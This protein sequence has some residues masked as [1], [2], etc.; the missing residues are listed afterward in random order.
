MSA[1]VIFILWTFTFCLFSVR[2]ITVP[3]IS[4][5]SPSTPVSTAGGTPLTITGVYFLQPGCAAPTSSSLASTSNGVSIGG[6]ANNCAVSSWTA[7]SIVC[8]TPAGTGSA[9]APASLRVVVTVPACSTVQ[10]VSG[11]VGPFTSNQFS[12]SYAAPSISSF[13]PTSCPTAGMFYLFC[14]QR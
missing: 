10:G 7:T 6:T 11:T 2:H 12:F 4:S 13:S 1:Q 3:T 9:S 8:T 5:I 14:L